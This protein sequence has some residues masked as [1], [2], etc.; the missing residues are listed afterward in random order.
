MRN[1]GSFVALLAAACL[2]GCGEEPNGSPAAEHHGRYH[3]IGT[4]AAGRMWSRMVAAERP[5]HSA[6]AN[7]A[8]D[9]QVIVV[10]DGQTGEVR[11]CGN[12]SGHCIG[13]NPWSEPLGQGRTAPVN[14]TEHA[15]DVDRTAAE[16]V[17]P[18]PVDGNAV[19]AATGNTARSTR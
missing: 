10:V 8:D 11:Q 3:G 14:L 4:Y 7:L 17:G 12:L 5:A 18:G 1:F 15:A 9:E 16:G 2:G 6:A 13:M 19:E